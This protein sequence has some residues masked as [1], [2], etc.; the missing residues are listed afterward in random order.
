[1]TTVAG[2]S[3]NAVTQF[4]NVVGGEI[5]LP[6]FAG[7]LAHRNLRIHSSTGYD[8]PRGRVTGVAW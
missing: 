1:V 5:Q 4:G 2:E 3:D 6:W 7:E 8:A